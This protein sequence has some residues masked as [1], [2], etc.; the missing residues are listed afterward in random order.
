VLKKLMR[1][2]ESEFAEG[3]RGVARALSPALEPNAGSH[4]GQC[5]SPI[6]AVL[7]IPYILFIF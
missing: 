4:T 1:A 3:G 2:D 7:F 5:T 6:P